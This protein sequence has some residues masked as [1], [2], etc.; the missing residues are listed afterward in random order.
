MSAPA[1]PKDAATV[2]LVREEA[3]RLEVLLLR[4]PDGQRFMG[5]AWVFPGGKREERDGAGEPGL[6][7]AAVREVAEEVGIAV[8][9]DDLVA[10]ARWVTPEREPVRFDARFYLAPVAADATLRPDAR[11]VADVAWLAPNEALARAAAGALRVMPP[12]L[13]NLELLAGYGALAEALAAAR[14]VEPPTVMPVMDVLDG[15]IAILLPGDP[16]HPD[17]VRRVPGP[18]R[19]VLRETGFRSE[20]P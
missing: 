5:G 6:R 19:I 16:L 2:I 17:P 10:W 3:G 7:A 12:T 4:R 8:A 18:T 13:R 15:A 14:T 1:V 20:D 11:E 9:P